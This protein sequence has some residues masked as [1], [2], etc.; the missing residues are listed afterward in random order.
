MLPWILYILL[1][2]AALFA[3]L[4]WSMVAC[5][6]LCNL[7]FNSDSTGIGILNA[8]KGIVLPVYLLWRL[9]AYAGHQKT[10]IAPI[11]W[12]LLA[13]YA[14]IAAS[15]S[16]F[17]LAAL[18]LAA[19]MIGSL[20]ICFVFLRAVKGDYLSPAVVVPVTVGT[21][22]LA[23]LHSLFDPRS[24]TDQ[25]FSSYAYAQTFAAFVA[26][27]YCI[28]LCSK[29]LRIGIRVSLCAVL[30]TTIV[31]DG[32]RI[33]FIGISIATLLALLVSE[34][35]P[36][37]KICAFGLAIGLAA[38]FVA[39]GDRIM[40]LVAQ[41]AESNRIAA[42]LTAA[43]EGD[44][45]SAGLGTYRFRRDA[46]AKEIQAIEASSITELIFGHGTSNGALVITGSRFKTGMDPNRL[47]H[48][49]W[50][51]VVYEWG[52]IG[53]TLWLMFFTSIT[54]FAL[55]GLR[56]DAY[57]FA[58]PL[59]IYLPAF[60]VA[61]AGEN[62]IAGAGTAANIG[63]LLLIALAGLSHRR[64]RRYV[65]ERVRTPVAAEL[66]SPVFER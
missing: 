56:N 54:V 24:A 30:A 57:G 43:Y 5:L 59:V 10:I 39:G 19:Q 51:R 64:F 60:A 29:S 41:R 17:P 61:L 28:A 63:F 50:L 18:K 55:Q 62:I 1:F 48:N 6:L 35:R 38:V 34:M 49:E 32:S 11:A 58:K 13:I 2:L 33:W 16:S 52:L 27:L 45:K 14:A 46:D 36:W 26:A 15:W 47:M 53:L 8:L 31:F 66:K 25:R 20:L 42:A 22:A 7:D 4:R 37:L 65:S 23:A 21:V 12:I 44:L 9:R 40:A 3:P